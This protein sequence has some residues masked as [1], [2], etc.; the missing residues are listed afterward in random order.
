MITLT[1][2][3]ASYDGTEILHGIDASF[4]SG[5]VS[6]IMGPNGCGKSTTIRSLIRLVP[7]VEGRFEM[8][9]KDLSGL[10]Q[11]ELARLISYLPQSRYVPEI[12]VE[13]LVMHGRFP[14]LNYPRRYRPEDYE[15][16][17]EALEQVGL[18]DL[19]GRKMENLS[20]G[21]RQ[22]ANLAMALA[23]D[24]DVILMDE[25]TTFL[26]IGNQFELLDRVRLLADAGK[27][28][29]M[30]LHDFDAALRYAD[31]ILLMN[32]GRVLEY[33][34]AEEVLRSPAVREAFGVTPC[35][36]TGEDGLHC[37]VRP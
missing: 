4:P 29:V 21:Q 7:E 26:D 37:Y 23:Q 13:R 28:V 1:G 33:G 25:P 18:T 34:N 22:K 19:A 10:S 24:T 5:K 11:Q 2:L 32:G 27:T 30:I 8:D 3:R 36:F 16:V 15:K 20:G 9:G 14:Y 35:F 6:V 17:A 12:T 31:R